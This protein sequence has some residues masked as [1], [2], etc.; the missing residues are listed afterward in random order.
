[1]TPSFKKATKTQSRARIALVGP[2]GSGKTYTALSLA[3]HL[4]DHVALI[5]TERGS[6]SKYAD[7][8]SFDVLELE[9]FSPLSY[10]EAIGAAVREGF[11]VLVIDSLSHAWSGAGGA[12]E[13]VDKAAKKNQ[14][15]NSFG[16]WREVTPLHNKLVDSILRADCHV[17]VTMRA[18]TDYVQEKDDR[19]R[20]QIRKVGLAPV[21]R[22]GLEYE[23][24]IVADIDIEHNFVVSK[25]R[26]K[27]LSGMVEN[28]AGEAVALKIKSWLTSGAPVPEPEQK[29]RLIAHVREALSELNAKGYQPQ[30]TKTTLELYVGDMFLGAP[31][32]DALSVEE[33]QKLLGDLNSK[34]DAQIAKNEAEQSL[35]GSR[36]KT[37]V[38]S[39]GA[40]EGAAN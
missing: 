39:A 19:G 38:N 36:A 17:I 31:G 27:A 33:L 35:A 21:Q 6:A 23:F 30:W 37:A 28:C 1:M 26:C 25:T 18:K 3:R 16:A 24:D 7:E 11:D 5:D 29:K 12:L 8:F 9:E 22:D 20:T 40:Q 13:L 4:G 32:L 15:G 34:L 14:S 2:S 10:V